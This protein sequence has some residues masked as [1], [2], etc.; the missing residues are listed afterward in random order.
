MSLNET[1]TNKY[2]GANKQA[3]NTGELSAI[4]MALAWA[5]SNKHKG[6][7]EIRYDSEVAA[8]AAQGYTFNKSNLVLINTCR[9]LMNTALN[10]GIVVSFLHVPAHSGEQGNEAADKLADL[11]ARGA[12]L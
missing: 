2:L 7:M 4:I 9:K 1:E 10:N 12:E 5:I 8:S 11:G 3:N 6:P